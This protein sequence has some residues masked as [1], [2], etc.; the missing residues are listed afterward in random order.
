MR[1]V[2][3]KHIKRQLNAQDARTYSMDISRA[4]ETTLVERGNTE[5]F[6]GAIAVI[7]GTFRTAAAERGVGNCRAPRGEKG[8]RG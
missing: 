8:R 4:K 3:S 6:T 7:F 5:T 2:G 1:F